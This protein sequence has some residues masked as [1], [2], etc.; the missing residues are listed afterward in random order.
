MASPAPRARGIGVAVAAV[1]ACVWLS[2]AHGPYLFDDW[3][4]PV[5]DPASQDIGSWAAR[6]TSTLRPLTKLTFAIEASAGLARSPG[7]RRALSALLMG[8]AALLASCL[9]RKRVPE[10]AAAALAL[11]WALHPVHADAIWMLAGRSQLLAMALALGA[12]LA[13]QGD[14]PRWAAVLFLC[15]VLARETALAAALPLLVLT[16]ERRATL[17]PSLIALALGCAYVASVPRHRE[18]LAFSFG[19][20]DVSQH[21]QAQLAALPRGT[22][23][24]L[25]PASLSFDHGNEISSS[26]PLALA[27]ASM[28]LAVLAATAF[29]TV[30][31][32][33]L[34]LAGA[35]WLAA[36]LPTN[37]IVPRIDPLTERPLGFAL[38]AVVLLLGAVASVERRVMTASAMAL[39][40]ILGAFTLRRSHVTASEVA[41]WADCA[42]HSPNAARTRYN[43]ALALLREGR[44]D[45][46]RRELQSALELD[47]FDPATQA[48][49]S[50]TEAP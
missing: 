38:L 21:L 19:A 17:A 10:G 39:A 26:L 45:A 9:L 20:L 4:T 2:G 7:A 50:R 25:A 14:R 3:I 22:L 49:L 28:L 43:H 6:A 27:G 31:R 33:P 29:A 34:A 24:L 36:M 46:A 11:L 15:A 13:A 35:V 42:Q 44:G 37:S 23:L 1:T 48:A 47:P 30:R 32:S 18:L 8:L 41:F 5:H 40:A 12:L 16:R